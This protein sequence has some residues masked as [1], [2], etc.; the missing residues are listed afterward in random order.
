MVVRW[1]FDD[2]WHKGPVPYSWTVEI[3]P[4]DGGSPE[5]QK[6][7]TVSQNLG[8]RRGAIVQEGHQG[9]PT[10]Q[11]SG[12]I[13]TQAHYETFEFWFSK[14]VLLDLTDDLGRIFRGIFS[15]FQPTRTRRA[16]NPWYHTYTAEFQAMAY[17]N[18]SGQVIYGRTA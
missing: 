9:I 10:I 7:L 4:S 14:R 1:K 5:V 18:A 8:P 3:N 15:S 17:T 6:S 16:F 11:F 13:L 2:V 12:S